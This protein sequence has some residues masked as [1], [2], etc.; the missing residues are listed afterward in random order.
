MIFPAC[1]GRAVELA[2]TAVNVVL[3]HIKQIFLLLRTL[4]SLLLPMFQLQRAPPVRTRHLRL[5][6]QE[7]PRA[8][9]HQGRRGSGEGVDTLQRESEAEALLMI[10][11]FS[12]VIKQVVKKSNHWWL[13]RN[14]GEEGSVPQNVL[15]LMSSGSPVENQQVS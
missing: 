9:R 13:I 5:R 6:G 2:T 3:L 12:L 11:V 4:L 14:R 8:E 15:E 7:W 10:T 1:K